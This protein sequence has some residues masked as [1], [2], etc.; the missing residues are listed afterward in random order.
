M[1][2]DQVPIHEGWLHTVDVRGDAP[3]LC[4]KKPLALGVSIWRNARKDEPS[5]N[6]Q[7]ERQGEQRTATLATNQGDEECNRP[8]QDAQND[9]GHERRHAEAVAE[10]LDRELRFRRTTRIRR[11]RTQDVADTTDSLRAVACIRFVRLGWQ[12]SWLRSMKWLGGYGAVCGNSQVVGAG[13]AAV[14]HS[15]A[16]K[17]GPGVG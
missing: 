12:C 16:N 1:K 15:Q 5:K 10:S 4:A 14:S 2:R 11:R 6:Q 8:E 17:H 13:A 7:R 9:Y 3:N